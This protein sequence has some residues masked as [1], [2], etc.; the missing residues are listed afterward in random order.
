LFEVLSLPVPDQKYFTQDINTYHLDWYDTT[1]PSKNFRI[2]P[3]KSTSSVL[4]KLLGF[5]SCP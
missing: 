4:G 2:T 5:I 3:W 1:E